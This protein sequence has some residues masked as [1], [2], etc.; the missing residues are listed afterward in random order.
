MTLP[1]GSVCLVILSNETRPLSNRTDSL[2][3]LVS[4][5]STAPHSSLTLFSSRLPVCLRD[6]VPEPDLGT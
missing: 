1:I 5:W 4:L 6:G 2:S 3:F